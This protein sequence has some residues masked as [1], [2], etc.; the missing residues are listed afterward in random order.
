MEGMEG[1]PKGVVCHFAD[2]VMEEADLVVVCTGVEANIDFLDP[3]HV[4]TDRAALANERMET[5]AQGLYAA[6]DA[7]EGINV[8]SGRHE[9]LATWENACL[10]GRVA[11]R[12]MAGESASYPGALPQ[13]I[14]PF[15]E[16]TYAQIG[17]VRS[18]GDSIVHRSFGSSAE[19][20]FL[21]LAFRTDVLVGANLINCAHLA[22]RL[23]RAILQGWRWEGSAHYGLTMDGVERA[24]TAAADDFCYPRAFSAP[25]NGRAPVA[26]AGKEMA[27][28]G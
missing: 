22:G 27:H 2:G 7:S 20:R 16:W 23:R 11:G 25:W 4:R 15:F 24:L 9:W 17:D 6:G 10:Q 13:N 12:N 18:S 21:V 1:A 19:G 28:H 8:L 3:T 26:F 14:A 5:S